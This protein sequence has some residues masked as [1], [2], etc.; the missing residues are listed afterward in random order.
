MLYNFF[1]PTPSAYPCNALHCHN[2][3]PAHLGALLRLFFLLLAAITCSSF[4]YGDGLLANGYA[5]SL[6]IQ[7]E[8]NDHHSSLDGE[9]PNTL[10]IEMPSN[11]ILHDP[12]HQQL[13][14]ELQN[15]FQSD[16]LWDNP[17]SECAADAISSSS[18]GCDI[19][20]NFNFYYYAVP[21]YYCSNLTI[22]W[23]IYTVYTFHGPPY[24]TIFDFYTSTEITLDS[25]GTSNLIHYYPNMMAEMGCDFNE[26][27]VGNFASDNCNFFESN[28]VAAC[29]DY[30]GNGPYYCTGIP[31]E[32]LLI[33]PTSEWS[34]APEGVCVKDDEIW[35]CE[36]MPFGFGISLYAYPETIADFIYYTE[37]NVC[38][39]DSIAEFPAG[40][41]TPP[42]STTYIHYGYFQ[43]DTPSA[44]FQ[45]MNT[46][47]YVLKP[48]CGIPDYPCDDAD[49]MTSND[50]YNAEGMC[51]G[52]PLNEIPL[53]LHIQTTDC[54]TNWPNNILK[55]QVEIIGGTMPYE[56]SGSY[57]DNEVY[58]SVFELEFTPGQP[59]E[60]LIT[61][62]NANEASYYNII[63][64]PECYFPDFIYLDNASIHSCSEDTIYA[65]IDSSLSQLACYDYTIK[66]F[67]THNPSG[68]ITNALAISDTGSF[69][70]EDII[71]GQEN[72]TYYLTA[73]AIADTSANGATNYIGDYI[74]YSA[75][76]PIRYAPCPYVMEAH[77]DFIGSYSND[78][79]ILI[80]YFNLLANDHGQG[81]AV[82]YIGSCADQGYT[83]IGSVSQLTSALA[84]YYP[85]ENFTGYDTLCYSIMDSLGQE[86]SSFFTLQII[87]PSSCGYEAHISQQDCI[88]TNA[89]LCDFSSSS[90]AYTL[91]INNSFNSSF[92]VSIFGIE[93]TILYTDSTGIAQYQF[94]A[95]GSQLYA[96]VINLAN[97]CMNTF[98]YNA[99]EQCTLEPNVL[100]AESFEADDLMVCPDNVFSITLDHYCLNPN[101]TNPNLLSNMVFALSDSILQNI[102]W[103]DV[104]A[105][106]NF[107]PSTG[108]TIGYFD[109][110]L[111]INNTQMYLSMGYLNIILGDTFY[112]PLID[113]SYA[114]HT[115]SFDPILA[116]DTLLIHADSTLNIPCNYPLCVWSNGDTADHTLTV[117]DLGWNWVDRYSE[118]GCVSR[119]SFYV[120]KITGIDGYAPT[121]N[122]PSLYYAY[123]RLY[124]HTEQ[125]YSQQQAEC[126]LTIYNAYGQRVY[127]HPTRSLS[128]G[129]LNI[130]LAQGV[131]IAVYGPPN[132]ECVQKLLVY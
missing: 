57:N 113:T 92:Q 63:F 66:Y 105:I 16:E 82:S 19:V 89:D 33:C 99:N 130:T 69:V 60:L 122:C 4:G 121:I 44:Y 123:D 50:V 101:Y 28:T 54:E 83:S 17:F 26:T 73:A 104:W 112:V 77:P 32:Q 72:Y 128:N 35:F 96:E 8:M 12:L 36:N 79:T 71:G 68:L 37:I 6:L 51:Q 129:V 15:Q 85:T 106:D 27:F 90:Y 39:G 25:T 29:L 103:K 48:S 61:D 108:D 22:I 107:N 118:G 95:P 34:I 67:I 46:E 1:A 52:S 18:G 11:K 7:K 53:Q 86:Q 24:S 87:D 75:S 126:Q 115:I 20:V 70:L 14:E 3:R 116:V 38:N 9:R 109:S 43:E 21:M 119:D 2:H 40:L 125:P 59:I 45:Q 98:S 78:Q 64:C 131:Y 62:P 31:N 111:F 55:I 10:I 76:K 30:F 127:Q 120:E 56:I 93:D 97:D 124:I 13:D 80:Q 88:N 81:L 41:L 42:F 65:A 74:L 132:K 110:S 114:L 49:L 5:Q 102:S 47:L 23:D 100:H 94:N 84:I 117:S 91:T 58:D